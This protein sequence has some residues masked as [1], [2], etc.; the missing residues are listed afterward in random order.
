MEELIQKR[1]VAVAR[2]KVF[3]RIVHCLDLSQKKALDLGCGYGEYMVKF[4]PNSSGITTTAA[5][6]EYGKSKGLDIVHGNVERINELGLASDFELVWANNLFEH[7][8]SPHAFLI[9]LK[10]VAAPEALLILGVPTIPK[11]EWLLRFT[12]FR[13]TLATNHIS[14]F[15]RKSLALTVSYAGWRVQSSRPYIFK[16][17]FLDNLAA[18]FAPHIYV[19]ARNDTDFSYPEKKQKEWKDEEY[20]HE[21][22]RITNTLVGK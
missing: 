3:N 9:K 22:F 12:K 11:F 19:V 18:W 1:F 5:E 15:T 17:K 16:N 20:Y 8:L 13:G 6:V 21:L 7:L 10:E 14:F 2:S 4:G